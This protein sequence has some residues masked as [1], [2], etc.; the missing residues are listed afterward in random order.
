MESGNLLKGAVY[1]LITTL[2]NRDGFCRASN[3]YLAQKLNR[4]DR[5]RISEMVSELEAE[6]WIQTEVNKG[7]GN[8]R[9]VW[10][11]AADPI[12]QKPKTSLVKTKDPSLVKTDDSIK[13]DSIKSEEYLATA[14]ADAGKEVNEVI[15]VFYDA[16]NKTANFGNKTQRAAAEELIKKVGQEQAIKAAQYAVK[17]QGQKYAPTITTPYQLR[18]KF[19]QLAIYAQ[20]NNRSKVADIS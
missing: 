1:G 9:K 16:G 20:K 17:V 2:C 4:K 10:I 12:R 5:S 14:K 19:A 3:A 13:R 7:A 6:G 11:A 18:E 15:A 8:Q